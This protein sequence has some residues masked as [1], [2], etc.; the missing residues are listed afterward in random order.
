MENLA[1]MHG[2]NPSFDTQKKCF[3]KGNLIFPKAEVRRNLQV[4]L[5]I[6]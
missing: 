3:A 2:N 4:Y 5:H 1:K 6:P